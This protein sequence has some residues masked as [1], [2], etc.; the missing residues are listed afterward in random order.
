MPSRDPIIIVAGQTAVGKTD[1]A[2][3]IAESIE[4]GGEC[5]SADSMQIYRGM[6][7]GTAKPTARQRQQVRHHMIDVANPHDSGFTLATW[8]QGARESIEDVFSRG[9]RPIVVGGTNLYIKSLLSGFIDGTEPDP[10]RRAELDRMDTEQL[11]TMLESRDPESAQRIHRNDR[12]RTIRAIEVFDSTGKPI[13]ALQEHWQSESGPDPFILVGLSMD[14][15]LL[16][17][18]INSRVGRMMEEGLLQEL[19]QLLQDGPLGRQAR[20]AVGY[21]QL[22]E[23]MEG[24]CSLEEAREQIKIQSRRYARQQ[25]TWLKR[26][27]PLQNSIWLDMNQGNP[28]EQLRSCIDLIARSEKSLDSAPPEGDQASQI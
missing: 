3:G 13:S 25:A 21:K 10:A 5:I 26:F 8:L 22:L 9:R 6:D 16:N 7:I 18:R 28:D 1:L 12:R 15:E 19:E 14:R 24:R 27:R 23:M 2:M 20:E 17:R 4:G 11:R